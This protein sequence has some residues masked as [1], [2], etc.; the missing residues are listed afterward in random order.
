M[1]KST[2]S[3]L[4]ITATFLGA[5]I[6]TSIPAPSW[7][8]QFRPDWVALVLIYWC[9]A[10]PERVGVG[11]GWFAGLM[12]DVLYGSILGQQ[13]MAKALM[14]FIVV[15]LHLRIRV[16]PRW[17]QALAV[18]VLL[19]INQLIVLWIKGVMGLSPETLTYWTGTIVGVIIWPWLFVILR[20]IRRRARISV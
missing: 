10:T 2:R 14:A 18:G 11:L 9:L 20:D 13:A 3:N 7:A 15:K 12:L 4:V 19:V 1:T 17:Q 8:E 16:Y 6:L 5:F